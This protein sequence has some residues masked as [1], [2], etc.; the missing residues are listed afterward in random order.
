MKK[1]EPKS[2]LGEQE[3]NRLEDQ[4]N[5]FDENVQSMTLDRMN[6][7]PK[8]ETEP[9]TK[10]SQSELSHKKDIYLKP[11]KSIGCAEK[12]NEKF[13]ES[14][15]F[16]K[17]YVQF[18]AE[19]KEII[20]D[21]IEMWTRP[22]PGMPAEY[23]TVPTNKPIWGPR[24]LAEQIHRKTYHRLIMDERV[25]TGSHGVGIDYGQ[26]AVDTIVPRLTAV[27]VSTRKSIFMGANGF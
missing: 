4:F 23:W 11:T 27:P 6:M 16:D 9:Q 19:N 13:R 2:T 1:P 21:N 24:Y 8:L 18:V 20:G 25:Q 3:L 14:Y 12:F 17:E 5:S 26:M 15:N 7:A 10:L 22:Y